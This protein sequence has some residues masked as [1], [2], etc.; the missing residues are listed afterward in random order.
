[1]MSTS[2]GY[3][4]RAHPV[5]TVRNDVGLEW[6]SAG[7][8]TAA[9]GW[10]ATA[11]GFGL[12]VAAAV[13]IGQTDS[14]DRL[15]GLLALT[16]G[17]ALAGVGTAMTGVAFVLRGIVKT[18]WIRVDSLK[19]ALPALRPPAAQSV[20]LAGSG[21]TDYG[22]FT[23]T[24]VEPKPL[25]VHRMAKALWAPMLLMGLMAV[26]AGLAVSAI[27]ADVVGGDPVRSQSLGVWASGTLFLGEGLLLGGISFLLGT[28]LSAI[29]R[30]GGEVQRSLGVAVKTLRMP[31]TAK[32]FLGL[33]AAGLM[34]EMAQL[35]FSAYLASLGHDPAS[36]GADTATVNTWSAWLGTLRFVGLGVMLSGVVLALATI[37]KALGFQFSRV[38][39]IITT[40]R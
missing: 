3:Q 36:A 40:G 13:A 20:V 28:I 25:P 29:R 8:A 24:D 31:T 35:G 27:Q 12:S 9:L 14:L 6:R 11:A 34:V 5:R 4:G 32:I 38:R 2:V 10:L 15:G 18:I 39:E 1:M 22:R 23:V 30:G 26:A 33:M 17:V 7:I 19:A 16:V 37:A 21:R